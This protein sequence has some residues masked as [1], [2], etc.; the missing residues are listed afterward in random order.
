M[1]FYVATVQNKPDNGPSWYEAQM[2]EGETPQA[3][4]ADA[5]S[6]AT[7]IMRPV[8]TQQEIA[9][10]GPFEL[11]LE[12][13]LMLQAVKDRLRRRTTTGEFKP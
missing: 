5:H 8:G 4:L 2:F 1:K 11:T 6:F 12:N 9:I 3:V 7:G 13:K 10:H